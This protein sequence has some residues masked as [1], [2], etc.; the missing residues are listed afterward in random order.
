MKHPLLTSGTV[1]TLLSRRSTP[2]D[3]ALWWSACITLCS[4]LV[5][6]TL[7]ILPRWK[8]SKSGTQMI[9]H[10]S[11]DPARCSK[12]AGSSLEC[13]HYHFRQ[14]PVNLELLMSNLLHMFLTDPTA[15]VSS[16]LAILLYFL[17]MTLKELSNNFE[18]LTNIESFKHTRANKN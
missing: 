10:G 5:D 3:M 8:P 16:R 11:T 4:P 12:H 15:I 17:P 2:F 7:K 6:G 18:P 9:K 1:P 14:A 13:L